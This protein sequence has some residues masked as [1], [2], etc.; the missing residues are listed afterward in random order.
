LKDKGKLPGNTL[1]T[2]VMAN[3]G[4]DIA[5]RNNDI[6]VLKTKVATDLF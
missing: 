4:L 5:M 2:T 3:L 6:K 1:V